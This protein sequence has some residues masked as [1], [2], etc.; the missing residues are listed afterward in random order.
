MALMPW[1]QEGYKERSA[2]G[3]EDPVENQLCQ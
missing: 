3:W 1:V 2:A